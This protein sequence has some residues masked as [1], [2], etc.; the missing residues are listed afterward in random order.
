MIDLKGFCYKLL[1]SS[2]LLGVFI[3]GGCDEVARRD[4]AVG[5]YVDAMT[6]AETDKTDEAVVK[7]NQAV[8]KD[9]GFAV[10]YSLLGDIYMHQQKFGESAKALEKATELN[11]W[12]I[13]DFQNLGKVYR[14]MNDYASAAKAY[15][16]AC[17]IDPQSPL[18]HRA[19]A[20]AYYKME[21]YDKALEFGQTAETL[22][23]VDVEI[24]KL[25]GDIYTARKDDE[26][27]IDVYKRAIEL[28]GN[29]PDIMLSLSVAYLRAGMYQAASELLNTVVSLDPQNAK[30]WRHLGFSS[31]SLGDVDMSIQ[32][33]ITSTDIAGDD[34]KSRKGLGVSYMMKSRMLADLQDPA[35]AEYKSK[36]LDEWKKSLDLNP[37]QGKLL[38]L[39]RKYTR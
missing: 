4:Q 34:Y 33:Y 1:I 11:P 26:M 3:V 39:Y 24:Q 7:L 36:A 27:A 10:A 25:L 32:Q 9:P 16:K 17:E 15:T 35:A 12:S 28:N 19:A 21:D 29:D 38:K 14:L 18:S 2:V 22:D 13:D 6:L 8:K 31:L 5:L 20:E 37:T 30:A 23:P